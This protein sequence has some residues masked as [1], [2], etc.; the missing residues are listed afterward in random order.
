[1]FADKDGKKSLKKNRHLAVFVVLEQ[2]FEI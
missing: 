2:I 1:M